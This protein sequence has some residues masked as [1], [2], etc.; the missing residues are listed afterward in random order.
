MSDLGC[1]PDIRILRPRVV[2]CTAR[3]ENSCCTTLSAK[4]SRSF[5]WSF[6]FCGSGVGLGICI[7]FSYPSD[8]SGLRVWKHQF[9]SVSEEV[10]RPLRENILRLL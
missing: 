2:L 4:L 3:V 7:F 8:S 9:T 5:S 6:G 1:G 10:F